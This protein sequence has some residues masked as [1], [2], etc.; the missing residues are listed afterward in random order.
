MAKDD[1]P[2][3]DPEDVEPAPA[4]VVVPVDALGRDVPE[5][6]PI[7]CVR[8]AVPGPGVVMPESTWV[9]EHEY[10]VD[11]ETGLISGLL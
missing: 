4:V 1:L 9:G 8:V 7:G 2:A 11:P 6:W 10:L 5:N 3:P